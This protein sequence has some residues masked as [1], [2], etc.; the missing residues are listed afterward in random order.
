[1]FRFKI[2]TLIYIS[3]IAMLW[4]C[5]EDKI[6][7]EG[8]GTIKGKVVQKGTNE[9]LENVKISTNPSTSTVFTDAEGTYTLSNVTEGDY[10]LAAE[11]EDLLAEFEAVTVLADKEVEIV[12]ELEISTANNRPPNAA[13]VIE[14]IDNAT[15][16]PLEIELKWSGSD[17]EEDPL[18][19]IVT[20]RNEADETLEIFEN[21]T[22]T[23]VTV[24]NLAYN[25]KYFWQVSS[26]DAINTPVNSAVFAFETVSF[27]ENRIVFTRQINQ[28]NVLFSMN[29]AGE[30]VQLT[31]VTKNSFR[32]RR[33]IMVDQIAFLRTIGA[34]THLFVMNRDGTEEQQVTTTV[35]ITGFNLNEIDYAW[36]DSGASLL[37]PNQNKLYRINTDGSGL[38]L[39]YETTNGNLITEV[40]VNTATGKIVVKTNDL[41]GYNVEIFTINAAGVVQEMILTGINGAAGG[42]DFSIGGDKVI[43]TRDVSGFENPDYRQLDSHIFIHDIGTMTAT[44]VSVE[45]QNGTNDLDVRFSPDEASVIFTNTSND[46]LSQLNIFI[47]E[48]DAIDNR[49]M[50]KENGSMPDWE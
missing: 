19:Y 43:Y 8:L 11:R 46:G 50:L 4:S 39:L 1:M 41:D 28:N 3:L 14:P 15:D 33:N 23:L 31:A 16:I 12:F 10:S 42:I 47:M 20:L 37:F 27:P 25:T 45:K 30:E 7:A 24:S 36:Y 44:D 26:N 40:D 32:P 22:D 21:L 35:P 34:E 6:D 38:T 48:I 2:N 5:S 29:E 49:T 18:T 13:T 17:P 9:P